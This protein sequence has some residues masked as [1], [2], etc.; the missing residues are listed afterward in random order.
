VDGNNLNGILPFTCA[1]EAGS[2]TRAAARLKVSKSAVGKAITAMERRLGVRLLN[3]TTRRLS[4]T[5]EGEAYYQA[6]TRALTELDAANALIAARRQVPSGRLRVDLPLAF[7]RRC[8]APILFEIAERFGELTLEISF[9]DH[10]IDLVEEGVDLAIRL[11]ELADVSGLAARQLCV[12]RSLACAAPGYLA[13]HG[14]P[15]SSGDLDG[16][17]LIAY[18]RA[19]FTNRP[20]IVPDGHGEPAEYRPHG[21]IVL[22]HGEPLLDAVLAGCGIAFLPTWLIGDALK[23]GELV[24]VISDVPV[25]TAAIHAI[26]PTTRTLAPKIRVVVD[27]LVERFASPPWEAAATRT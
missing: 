4:L 16:H 27:T 22:A 5:S 26:W 20:W 13:T 17:S 12:Q 6:C 14:R 8:V 9:N 24:P 11:G 15:K 10:R 21:R 7:G 23:R 3:R 19:G 1:V 25:E 2:L 18:G